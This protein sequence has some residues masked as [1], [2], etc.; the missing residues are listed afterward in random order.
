VTV[1]RIVVAASGY[2]GSTGLLVAGAARERGHDVVELTDL[3]DDSAVGRAL[4]GADAIVLIPRRGNA[5]RHTHQAVRSLIAAAA[6]VGASP[7]LVLL[8]SFAVG[9]GPAHPLNRIDDALLPGRVA[10]EEELRAGGLPYTIVRPTWF[11]DDPPGS[12]ALTFTQHPRPDGMVARADIAATLVA[13]VEIPA[14][15][16]T[17]FALYNEPGEP[18]ADWAAAFAR[19]RP[20]TDDQP[21]P[22]P[23]DLS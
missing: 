16:S 13:A 20:D 3:G 8:S 23:E 11:T 7:H 9:H 15:R 12:H 2:R 21:G 14:A 19:L 18:A 22:D 1:A 6:P 5:W 10:A 17:T 4:T